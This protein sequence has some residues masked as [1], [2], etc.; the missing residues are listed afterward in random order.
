MSAEKRLIKTLL[1]NYEA[2]GK[3]GRPV[4]NISQKIDV[5]FGLGLIQMDLDEKYKVLKMSMWSKYVSQIFWIQM[6]Y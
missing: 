1:Q 3:S 4:Y 2:V 6:W 5:E